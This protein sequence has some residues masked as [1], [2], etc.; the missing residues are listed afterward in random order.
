MARDRGIAMVDERILRDEILALSDII[1]A[2]FEQN[3]Q[4]TEA[5]AAYQAL[6]WA[7]NPRGHNKPSHW[8]SKPRPKLRLIKGSRK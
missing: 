2:G 8:D 4:M 7:L 1:D 6:Q 5:C 3:L